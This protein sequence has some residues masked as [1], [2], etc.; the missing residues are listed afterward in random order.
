[1]LLGRPIDHS[2]GT[3]MNLRYLQEA[4]VLTCSLAA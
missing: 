4:K 1:M 3:C 2:D